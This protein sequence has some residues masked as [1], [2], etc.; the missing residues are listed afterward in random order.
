MEPTV[1]I[2]QQN[3]LYL[4]RVRFGDTQYSWTRSLEGA[5]KITDADAMVIAMYSLS[6]RGFNVKALTYEH[7]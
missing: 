7:S 5:W 4:M 1:I 6:L 3:N 2:N